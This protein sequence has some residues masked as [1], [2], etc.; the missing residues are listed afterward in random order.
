M[1]KRLTIFCAA[2]LVACSGDSP[3]ATLI[4]NHATIYTA[5]AK[6]AFAEAV[7]ISNDRIIY[8]GDNAGATRHLGSQTRVI[9]AAGKVVLPGLHD[10]HIHPFGL[11]SNSKCD[12][13]SEPLSLAAL[14]A[15]V[16]KCIEEAA[17]PDGEWLTVDQ[18]NF[19]KGNQPIESLPTLRAALDAA[20]ASHPIFLR[21]N[22]GHHGGANSLALASAKN[23]RNV[24]IGINKNT[25]KTEFAEY[26]QY[27][28]LD[29]QGEP[30]GNVS[31]GARYL[32][33]LE[34]NALTGDGDP[35]ALANK[36]PHINKLL[37]RRGI[38]SIQDAASDIETFD[39]YEQYA[40]SGQQTFRMTA[41]L[42]TDFARFSKGAPI[43]E[44]DT[45]KLA[46]K[47]N[48]KGAAHADWVTQNSLQSVNISAVIK[49]FRQ[50][51]ERQ[52]NP[53][54]LKADAAKIFIDG[55]IEG[56]PYSDPPAL[57]NAA[58]YQPYLQPR[59]K[60]TGGR[61]Q[62]D[63][64]IDTQAP[65]CAGLNS[66]E[67]HPIDDRQSFYSNWGHHPEQCIESVGRLEHNA[68]FIKKYIYAL[69]A[70]GFA[71][72]AHAI[73]DRAVG[74][75]LSTFAESRKS[76][77]HSLPQTISHAQQIAPQDQRRLAD[78]SVF[79]ALTF[80]WAIPDYLY[81]VTVTPFIDNL[82]SLAAIYEP[83]LYAMQH[84][85]AKSALR[86]G[87]TI[88]AGSD[89]PV[90]TRDPRPFVNIAAAVTRSAEGRIYNPQERLSMTEALDAYTLNG[91][92]ALQ[93]DALTGSIE[94]GKKADLIMIDRDIFL[95]A[96]NLDAAGISKTQVLMTVFDGAIVYQ[97]Q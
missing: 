23:K 94:V 82:S 15:I 38:T 16:K 74:V 19:T 59:F 46:A 97:Q 71:V 57:P 8:V 11:V 95:D 83:S 65:Q 25:V 53:E 44:S 54:L 79:L 45:H 88:V 51:R 86:Q 2:L 30:D 17:L 43:T 33:A 27:I 87:A 72:H 9:N 32:L 69:E 4:I 85:P 34:G 81:D 31:E 36:M 60:Q 41:A 1:L 35:A 10:V 7:A 49:A 61:L 64:Y 14:S 40:R 20:S 6:A 80:A 48:G 47:T 55:V 13:K 18:W 70:A 12:L 28:G 77:R 39:V 37:N 93:Q 56:N 62:L 3:K 42:I 50:L 63:G 58:V 22:D 91:A 24:T 90:D 68:D 75:A 84:Y 96:K 76:L 21:G 78:N 5:D 26:Q 29:A 66:A 52:S 67:K 89:A 73:G 92:K